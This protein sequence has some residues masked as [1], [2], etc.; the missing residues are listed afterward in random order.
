MRSITVIFEDKEFEALLKENMTW[1]K[2]IL[3][4]TNGG[5]RN[6]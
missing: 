4:L 1:R 2:F 5:K 3:K 6:E